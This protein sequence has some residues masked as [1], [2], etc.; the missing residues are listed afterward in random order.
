MKTEV[1]MK[2]ELFGEQIRQKSKSEYFCASDLVNAGNKWRIKNGLK[3][4][5][6]S[7]WLKLQGTIEFME[8]LEAETGMKP[9]IKGNAKNSPSWVHPFLFID[10][11]LALSPSLK[12]EAYKWMYDELLKYRNQS[13]DSYKRMCGSLYLIQTDKSKFTEE[14][15]ELARRIKKE[16]GVED[17]ESA[18]EKQ[19]RLRDKIHEN[20]ALL[21]DV[22]RDK[23][24]LYSVAI[25][26]AKESFAEEVKDELPR[27]KPL[28]AKNEAK[29]NALF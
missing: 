15:K 1:V 13:G 16:V 3:M 27:T 18:T 21:S 5:N 8:S 22:V 6:F 25:R 19:L 29:S 11:A 9:L 4:F 26:K 12:V 14:L 17:W 7:Q 24:T 2:R 28:P 23:E 20:I 10:L